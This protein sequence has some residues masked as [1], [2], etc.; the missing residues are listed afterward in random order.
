MRPAD[1]WQDSLR[2]FRPP[3][4]VT[5]SHV[6]LAA[7]VATGLGFYARTV[8][9]WFFSDDFWFLHASQSTP[10][11]DYLLAAFNFRHEQYVP[12]ILYRPLCVVSFRGLFQVFGLHAWA[13]HLFGL[14]LHLASGVLLWLIAV[15]ITRRPMVGH[16]AALIFLLHPNYV[17]AVAFIANNLAAAVISTFAGLSSLWLF[18]LYL[19]GGT[20][21][22]V[23]YAASFLT[24]VAAILL[25]PETSY[26]VAL[27]VLAYVLLR[28]SS[29]RELLSVRAWAQFVP[30]LLI[31]IGFLVTQTLAREAS[32]YQSHNFQLG[33]HMM[34]NYVRY[35]A[36]ALDPYRVPASMSNFQIDLA[37]LSDWRTVLPVAS[38][39]AAGAALLFS[40][41]RRPH[42]GTFA[43]LWFI[44]AVLPLSTWIE[45]AYGRKLY[46]AGPALALTVAIF[47]VSAWD[48]IPARLQA[49]LRY[50]VP[51]HY[52]FLLVAISMGIRVLQMGEPIG[53]GA[54]GYQTLV[55]EVRHSYPTLPEGSR[56]YL[57]GVPW[58]LIY[59]SADSSGL[60]SAI[61]LY[62]GDIVINAV[63]SPNQLAQLREPPTSKDVVFQYHCPPVCQPPIR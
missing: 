61:Q 44:L 50:L 49:G 26:L 46:S 51:T 19:D 60:A 6:V 21:R 28:A 9:Y 53:Q 55:E 11:G 54:E 3:S 31:G 24:F 62:Y 10:L 7:I 15:K 56:L 43:L 25:H 34:G 47:A 32:T 52:I 45:G 13:Y 48:L 27:L 30:F 39:A 36:L 33:Q 12:E 35:T 58:P 1:R 41:R 40:E 17:V 5:P 42:A 4:W 16:L 37:P 2:A 23:Y 22:R 57:V 14:S 20:R 38:G 8:G 59:G 29:L 18:L 63:V